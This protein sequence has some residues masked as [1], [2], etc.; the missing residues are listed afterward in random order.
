MKFP[1]KPTY[2]Y[3]TDGRILSNLA[4]E[5]SDKKVNIALDIETT[6]LRP[7]D[8]RCRLVQVRVDDKTYV[9]DMYAVGDAGYKDLERLLTGNRV[10]GHN[11]IFE[12]RWLFKNGCR[13]A[14]F[15]CRDSFVASKIVTNGMENETGLN[16]LAGVVARYLDVEL[17]K[18]EQ[19]SNWDAELLTEEQLAY[20]AL[21]VFYSIEIYDEIAKEVRRLGAEAILNLENATVPLAADMSVTGIKVDVERWKRIIEANKAEFE[22][23]EREL[24]SLC[25][26]EE[27]SLFEDKKWN[28]KSQDEVKEILRLL[29]HVVVPYHI[30]N[31]KTGVTKIVESVADA[32]LA[33]I[34][35]PVAAAR[36]AECLRR[37]RGLEKQLSTYGDGLLLKL[38]DNRFHSDWMPLGTDTGRWS[39]RD[40][41]LT[42]MPREAEYRA[43]FVP[44][45]GNVYVIA[46][47]SQ[48]EL[49][50]AAVIA[51]CDTML[52]LF[53]K[54]RDPHKEFAKVLKGLR[55]DEEP[56]KQDR[57]IAKSA[58]FGLLYGMGAK[59]LRLYA[60]TNYG[61]ELSMQEA[62]EIRNK[63]K[64][65]Y[66]G[67]SRWHDTP[68]YSDTVRTRAGRP[69]QFTSDYTKKFNTPV[70]GTGADALKY[71]LVKLYRQLQGLDAKI[72]ICCHDEIVVECKKEIAEE[73]AEML[74]KAMTEEMDRILAG[75]VPVK[76]ESTIGMSWA[77]KA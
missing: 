53:R 50:I 57:Q 2:A 45:E 71:A 36:F 52:E 14:R 26:K 69:R 63:W 23:V 3:V 70:Q 31:K 11:L 28:F 15:S 40:P 59:K 56:T 65:Y 74:S 16:S 5:F 47:Y 73:I 18:D 21:D 55:E 49:R 25:P 51:D 17:S 75:K 7:E 42:N 64:E 9:F 54:D 68:T 10:F 1:P 22:K 34:E 4:D 35:K 37:W 58:N 39:S 6:D 61:V 38:R 48:I 77:D 12:F 13:P 43:C 46:D 27:D 20:A 30:K 67:I 32:Y 19:T 60:L 33:S 72:V 29:G 24:Q 44:G 8:G 66:S 76:A 41:N 62:I